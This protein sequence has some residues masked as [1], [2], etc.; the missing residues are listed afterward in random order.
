[1]L[2]NIPDWLY[3]PLPYLYVL[4][5]LIATIVLEAIVGKIS[6]ILLISAGFVIWNLRFTYRRRRRRPQ[7]RDLSWGANQRLHPPKGLDDVQK[8]MQ[9]PKKPQS[10]TD[11]EDL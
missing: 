11:D 10:N 8:Q 2:K 9:A 3:E 4:M 6:G 5:G 7:A 1:M